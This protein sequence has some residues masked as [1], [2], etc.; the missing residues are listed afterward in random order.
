MFESQPGFTGKQSTTTVFPL[1][2]ALLF[3]SAILMTPP[4]VGYLS[5]G[6]VL[7]GSSVCLAMAKA[8]WKSSAAAIP[9]IASKYVRER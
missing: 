8:S 9:A 1:F 2:T 7:A 4:P 6:L 5:V 3:S